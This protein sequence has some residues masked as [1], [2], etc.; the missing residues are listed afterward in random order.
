MLVHFFAEM[1][2]RRK[3]LRFDKGLISSDCPGFPN[4]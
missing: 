4:F 3:S 2:G 1:V